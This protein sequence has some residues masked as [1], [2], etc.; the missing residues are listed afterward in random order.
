M[1]DPRE[2][3]IVALDVSSL[4]AARKIVDAVSDS[5]SIYKIGMQL[6]TAEGPRAVDHRRI[7]A[8]RRLAIIRAATIGT[9]PGT[10]KD[11]GMM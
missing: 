7:R 5:A 8:S 9:V 10:V 6:F 4:A 1:A 3:L 11:G 2:R